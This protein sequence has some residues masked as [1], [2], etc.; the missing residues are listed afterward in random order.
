MSPDDLNYLKLH[1]D[2]RVQFNNIEKL[3]RP[4]GVVGRGGSGKV[5]KVVNEITNE[6]L[7]CKNLNLSNT[8]YVKF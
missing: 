8:T 2:G 6:I 4:V 5:I 3:Y 1:L 7:S